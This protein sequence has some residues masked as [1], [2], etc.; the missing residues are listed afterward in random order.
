MSQLLQYD[1]DTL[2]HTHTHTHTHCTHTHTV[3]AHTPTH[4]HT[5]HTHTLYTHAHCTHTHTVHTRTLYTHTHCTHTRTHTH[6]LIG[7][8]RNIHMLN[9]IRCRISS[10][11]LSNNAPSPLTEASYTR[12]IILYTVAVNK[13]LTLCFRFYDRGTVLGRTVKR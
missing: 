9:E 5:V 4:T 10:K 2:T 7:T 12:I 1:V 8:Y 6:A 3:H 13:K 11:A